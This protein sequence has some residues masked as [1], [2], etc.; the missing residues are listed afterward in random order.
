MD[1][2]LN[3]AVLEAYYGGSHAAFVDTLKANSRHRITLV[4]LPARK[5]KW[6]M[7]GAA[8]WLARD[9]ST[10]LRS[11]DGR[12]IDAIVCSDMLSVADLRALLPRGMRDLPIACY[13]HENQ[14]TYPIPAGQ[15]RDFQYGMTNISS[16]MASDAVW[17][18]SRFHLD[19]FLAAA[20]ELL[21]KMPD[22]VPNEILAEI[23]DKV[24]VL[25]PPVSVERVDRAERAAAQPLTIL[26]CHRW[27]YDKNPEP[28]LD[29]L[30]RLA[31]GGHEFG[32][33]LVGEQ[34]RVAPP[35]FADACQRLGRHIVHSGYCGS[36]R[37]YAS[38]LAR[39]DVV[40][41]TAIQENFGIAVIE[42]AL[43]GCQPLLPHRL[44]YPEIIPAE[45]H[46]KCL[47][48]S[49]DDLYARLRDLID[50]LGWLDGLQK[51]ILQDALKARYGLETTLSSLDQAFE[52]LVDA[53]GGP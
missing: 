31:A 17:F 7:R 49:D 45:F 9:G 5:W 51:R 39:C 32:V 11:D 28:F 20:G 34:F 24:A 41:S 12:P 16:C 42:A 18:N 38:L 15:E 43:A 33:V 30:L 40:V 3:V 50:G 1:R 53:G 25:P 4:T 36:R 2:R 37:E 14:L 22:Y 26:W 44:A 21:R 48:G 13:F 23:R 47:Y 52:S 6:R 19:G 10:W 8:I 46:E 27:E 35:A 29:A